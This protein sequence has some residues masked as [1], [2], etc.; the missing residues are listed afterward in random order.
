MDL[1]AGNLTPRPTLLNGKLPP[2]VATARRTA[3]LYR[4][5]TGKHKDE[6]CA[7]LI[8]KKAKAQEN[9]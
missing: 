5:Y 9:S 4:Y 7:D 6:F 8:T 2:G 3:R 1:S